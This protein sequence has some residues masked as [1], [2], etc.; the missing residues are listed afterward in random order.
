[1]AGLYSYFCRMSVPALLR[2][3]LPLLCTMLLGFTAHAQTGPGGVGNSTSNRLW[4]RA[5][6]TVFNNAGT[7]LAADGDLVQQWND[8]SGNSNNASQATPAN[9]PTYK[10]NIINGKPALLFAGNQ[11]IDPAAL[12][13]PATNGFSYIVVFNPT[14]F[15]AG[16]TAD[17]AGDYIIDRTSGTNGLASL[18]IAST[19]KYMFQKRDDGGG[20]LGG[21]VSTTN[22]TTSTFHI[23]DYTRERTAGALYRLFLDGALDQTAADADGNLTPPTPRIGRHATTANNGIKGYISELII[24]NYRVNDAQVRILNSYLAAKYNLPISND[25]YAFDATHPNDVAGLGSEGAGLDNT[26]AQSAG[27]LQINLPSSLSAGDYLLFGHDNASISAWTTTEA[28]NAGTDIQRLSR[29]WRLN[30][31]G[32]D[33]G[34]TRFQVDVTTLPAAPAGHTRYGLMVDSDGDFSS[35]ATVYEMSLVAG[36]LYETASTINTNNGDFVSIAA[37]RP[38]MQFSTVSG[39]GFETT[40]AAVTA[41]LN[42]VAK[43]AV[44]ATVNTANGSAVAPGDYT[45]ISGGTVTI[46]AGSS[47]AVVNVT[48]SNDLALESDETFTVTLSAPTGG[49]NLGVNSVYTHTIHDD[50]NA[51]KINFSLASSNGNENV[52]AVTI[53]VEDAPLDAINP[54][55]VDYF[56]SGGTATGGG[57]DF[58]LASGTATIPA[59]SASVTIPITVVDDALFETNETIIVTMI[60]PVNCNLNTTNTVHTYTIIDND[61]SPSVAFSTTSSSGVESVSPVNMTV[62]LS[63]ISGAATTVD[64]AVTGGTATNGGVDYTLTAG[65]LTIPANSLTGTLSATIVNDAI[66]ELPETFIVTLSSP[67]NATLGANTTF[68][69]SIID[70]DNL[71]ITGPGGVGDANNNRLW[72]SADQSAFV[73]A[74]TTLAVN[75]DAVQQWN[76]RSGNSNHV[77]QGTLANRPI[78]RTNVVNSKPALNYTG[79]MFLDAAALGIAGSGGFSYFVVLNPTSFVAGTNGDGNGDYIFDRTSATTELSGLKISNTNKY[80]FQI[81]DNAGAGLGGPVSTTNVNTGAFQLVDFSRVRG[82]AFNLYVNGTLENSTADALGNLTPPPTRIGRHA[83]TVNGG[84][85]GNLTEVAIYNTPLNNAQRTIVENY[86]AAK[87]A[88]TISNDKFA[89]DATHGNDVAG[90]GMEDATNFHAD[91]K[92]PSIVR[93][94]NPSSLNNLDYLLWG[95]D[96]GPFSTTETTD[97]PGAQ[98]ILARLRR[99]WRADERGEVGTIDITF[100]LTGLGPVV[101]SDLRLL[102]SKTDNLFADETVAGGTI[103]SGATSLGGN[104]YGFSGVNI[105]NDWRFTLGTIN[106]AQTPLPVELLA[107]SAEPSG[108][109]VVV[110]WTTATETN[111]DYFNVER[112]GSGDLSFET[113]SRVNAA[114]SSFNTIHYQVVDDRPLNGT[115]YYR[116]VQVDIDGT[117]SYSK[118]AKVSFDASSPVVIYPNPATSTLSVKLSADGMTEVTLFNMMGA[119]VLSLP[120]SNRR[121]FTIACGHLARGVYLVRVVS[122]NKVSYQRVVLH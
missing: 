53:T 114:G 84:L 47:T 23:V 9:R 56:V 49:V 81:R 15:T 75:N 14:S 48:V 89:F 76:D 38:T 120:P 70:N 16:G 74:G 104:V 72:L 68:T 116:L 43:T 115:S 12:G 17:G 25:K 28:P 4:L 19:N 45:A 86:L 57:V 13:I 97:V 37:I 31:T 94:N 69:Y 67:T 5:D 60:N 93:I 27:I 80:G 32:T 62:T 18:K 110:K 77:S 88:L 92:G 50:D 59:N 83:S 106:T 79:N 90:I 98:G 107:F 87:Y 91:A 82:S 22:V 36:S 105:D 102:I 113:I 7:V 108:S 96:G 24:Y 10:V 99:V 8:R 52:T 101:A 64:Y 51:R 20:G 33:A 41:T 21:P 85:K 66:N 58:T 46:A 109:D 95:H 117:T 3:S 11:F 55:S 26:D 112:S 29:E 71:G 78:F 118:L 100:D 40:N 73:N 121:E 30:E 122:G 44:S 2:Q 119:Q 1:M 65:T 54:T 111:S 39:T 6:A 61:L 103:L 34:T 42:Y 35:G 63:A